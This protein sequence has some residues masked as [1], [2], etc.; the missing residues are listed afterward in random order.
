MSE[1]ATQLAGPGK[2]ESLIEGVPWGAKINVGPSSHNDHG[3][4]VVL[5]VSTVPT[6]TPGEN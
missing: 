3:T 6:L 1:A 4:A 2:W 5:E